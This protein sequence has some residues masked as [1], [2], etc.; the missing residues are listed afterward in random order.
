[1][2]WYFGPDSYYPALR[3][4]RGIKNCFVLIGIRATDS[5]SYK[6]QFL[7][8]QKNRFVPTDNHTNWH[9]TNRRL[10][11]FIV[12][13]YTLQNIFLFCLFVPFSLQPFPSLSLR[14]PSLPHSRSPPPLLPLS[15]PGPTPPLSTNL[16]SL[17]TLKFRIIS[18][19]DCVTYD[20]KHGSTL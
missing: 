11:N 18:S 4:H 16:T 7:P 14:T 8:G 12:V 20:P 3:F 6:E 5:K 1:M 2:S 9:R 13:Y 17:P 10:Q 19:S 15:P